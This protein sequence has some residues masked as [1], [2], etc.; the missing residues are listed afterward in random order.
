MG[1]V[2]SRWRG[3]REEM[4]VGGVSEGGEKVTGGEASGEEETEWK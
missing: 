3:Q 4:K 1:D 2:V